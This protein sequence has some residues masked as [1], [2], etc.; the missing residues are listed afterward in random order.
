[1]KNSLVLV[2]LITGNLLLASHKSVLSINTTTEAPF[3]TASRN[4][5]LDIV[6]AEVFKRQ[7]LNYKLVKL[8]AER[9]LRNVNQGIDDGDLTRIKGLERIYPNLVRVPEKLLY[10]EFAAF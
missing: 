9:G 2:F 1:M 10:W 4:G 8:P 5:F 3:T 7:G 6:V